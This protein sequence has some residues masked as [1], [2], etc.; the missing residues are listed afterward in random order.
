[1]R[2]LEDIQ[3]IHCIPYVHADHAWTNSR[4]WHIK[5]YVEGMSRVLDYMH[6]NPAYT[7][8]IDNVLHYYAVIERFLPDRLEE[9]RERVRQGRICIANGG[10]SLARPYN[11]GDELYL[12]NAV[13]GRQALQQ[14]FP[15][16]DIFMFFNADTGVGHSQLPQLLTLTG[17]SHYRFFRPENALDHSG[18][19]REFIWQGL[20]GTQI[21][22]TRGYYGSF[23]EGACCD[24]K[25]TDWEQKKAAFIKEELDGRLPYTETN[26][27]YLNIGSDDTF[28][29]K[30]VCDR[31]TD[32]TGFMAQW[33][34]HE[35]SRMFYST[36]RTYHQALTAH[37]L[38]VW[39]GPCDPVD[40][41]YNSPLRSAA[42]LTR[43]RFT[44]EQLL[45]QAERL[46]VILKELGGCPEEA[47]LKDL[48]ALLFTYSGHAMQSLLK[49]D[50]DEMLTRADLA[51]AQARLY[52]Q[53]LLLQIAQAAG[54]DRPN[55][56]VL[57]NPELYARKETV[58]LLVTTAEHVKGL[59]LYDQDG[60][61]ISYQILDGYEGDKP[62][63]NKDYNEVM[64]AFTVE[65]PPMG[66][67]RV[68]AVNSADT[69]LPQAQQEV[70]LW[71]EPIEPSS[72][73]E[74]D[75]GRYCFTVCNG[76]VTKVHDKQDPTGDITADAFGQLRFYKTDVQIASG[77]S[78]DS[79]DQD[80]PS[81][82][83]PTQVKYLQR[84]P[85]L[86]KLVLS[87]T[88]YGLDATVTITTEKDSPTLH[89]TFAF[90][91]RGDIGYFAVAFPCRDDPSILAGI[92]FGAEPRDLT[93]VGYSED[94][95]IPKEDYLYFERS[96][97][98]GF[99]ANR[100]V[101]F[102]SGSKR[103]LLTQDD[104]AYLYRHSRKTHELET[105]LMRSVNAASQEKLWMR[106][107]HPSRTGVGPNS[108]SFTVSV[109]EQDAPCCVQEKIVS[110]NRFP[111]LSTP[112]YH[113]YPLPVAG[114]SLFQTVSENLTVTACY[115][116]EDHL[117]LRLYENS[118]YG[119]SGLFGIHQKLHDAQLCDLLGQ[120]QAQLPVENGAIRLQI[121]PWQIVNL[122][123][124]LE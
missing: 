39:E 106:N 34:Q 42:A 11:Y 119:F 83:S 47:L 121:R 6:E 108:F 73:V 103:I 76:V 49:E 61:S 112:L 58:S 105:F 44:T 111:V 20:D 67:R 122:R 33:N 60:N 63:V 51:I 97:E 124:K 45:L 96:C 99:C 75:N 30:N 77:T 100:F 13:A 43:L 52:T 46:Q 12:R 62:Y 113:K 109:L 24:E 50:Y 82:F 93:K 32:I 1:M 18:V 118:G 40:L 117:I 57:I 31:D 28:P 86:W 89:F 71:A 107:A 115:I 10:M 92:P 7:F 78:W 65:L 22:A 123:L 85:E 84:G 25:H 114:S 90:D 15:E 88:L 81:G 79:W 5:R 48:W 98:G 72:P 70:F 21:V 104:S 59:R 87:G 23:M 120:T 68:Y 35:A 53:E 41:F 29:Q 91:C 27:L 19:P 94:F 37:P 66:I 3:N 36:P 8:L 38:P 17:H 110:R 14:R 26:E 101:S 4:Q 56:Y 9:V 74:L 64:V 55:T 54:S 2:K 102:L 80:A 116:Q 95:H 69:M 16:A